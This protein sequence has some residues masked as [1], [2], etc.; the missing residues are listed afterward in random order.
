MVAPLQLPTALLD[1]LNL[2][3][4]IVQAMVDTIITRLSKYLRYL[5]N[6]H[7]INTIAL[8]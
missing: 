4:R 7:T 6:Y 2:F 3:N 5:N 1:Y 8:T